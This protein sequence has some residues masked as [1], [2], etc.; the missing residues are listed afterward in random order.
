MC[1]RELYNYTSTGN[2]E[3][4][5]FLSFFLGGIANVTGGAATDGGG[6]GGFEPSTIS[7]SAYFPWARSFWIA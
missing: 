7:A 6:G 5:Y 1:F 2:K 4:I 3:S